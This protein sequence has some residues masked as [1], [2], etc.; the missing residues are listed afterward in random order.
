[1][2]SGKIPGVISLCCPVVD[3][4]DCAQA[5]LNCIKFDQAQNKRFIMSGEV[6]WW[7]DIA[8]SLSEEFRPLG[9]KFSTTEFKYC[10]FRLAAVFSAEAKT[11]LPFW[12]KDMRVDNSASR[13]V[14]EINY[15]NVRESLNEM[16]Y[17]MIDLGMIPDKRKNQ[18]NTEKKK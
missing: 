2:L 10:T 6:M 12:G 16:A 9:Y 14:L 7:R 1:M 17:S 18:K 8:K 15:R 11:L 3:V 4:R 13:D 5:H